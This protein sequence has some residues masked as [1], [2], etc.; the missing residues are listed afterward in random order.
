VVLAPQVG[1]GV[2]VSEKTF[3]ERPEELIMGTFFARPHRRRSAW[4]VL[5]SLLA[6]PLFAAPLRAQ[7]ETGPADKERAA[8]LTEMKEMVQKIK[9]YHLSEDRR[10]PA[11]LVEEAALRMTDASR[12][13]LDGTVWL[14]YGNDRP[15][16][17][18]QLWNQSDRP[19][20]W[21]YSLTSLS[22]G[23][24][25]AEGEGG[26]RWTPDRPGV[27]FQ[28]L[29]DAPAPAE[30]APARLRQMKELARRFTAHEFW[31]P[32]N[33]RTELRLLVQPIHRYAELKGEL[34]DGAV[35]AFCHDTD[36]E[37]IL[38]IEAVGQGPAA[39]TWRFAAAPISSAELHLEMDRRDVWQMPR[40]PGVVGAPSGPYWLFT[41]P[42]R[43]PRAE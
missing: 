39:R 32:N 23:L 25:A 43:H 11:K 37:V 30:K 1:F 3:H 7:P 4:G 22:T 31:D 41:P 42:I 2:R 20:S 17:I 10:V 6:M 38:L 16:A 33:Q 27:K 40:A 24:V 13:R 34:L 35:F 12:Q 26:W 36:P 9:V 5:L 29:P 19:G 28:P 21:D 15:L 18:L 14:W 8:R